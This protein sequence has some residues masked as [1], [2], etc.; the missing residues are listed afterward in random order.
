MTT[1][2]D[3][4][5]LLTHK[6]ACLRRYYENMSIGKARTIKSSLNKTKAAVFVKRVNYAKGR[7]FI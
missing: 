1:T 3:E 6:K 4:S 7:E 2:K 5:E